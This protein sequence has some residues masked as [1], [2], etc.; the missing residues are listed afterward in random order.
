MPSAALSGI[1]PF[2]APLGRVVHIRAIGVCLLNFTHRTQVQ[3]DL[4]ET[5]H[6]LVHVRRVHD[7]I[8]LNVS[9]LGTLAD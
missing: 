2:I 3:T 8:L 4:L 5:R 9:D 6:P 7:L 1:A